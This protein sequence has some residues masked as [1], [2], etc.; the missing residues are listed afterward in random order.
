MLD[1]GSS[2]TGIIGYNN[3]GVGDAYDRY[4]HAVV[5]GLASILCL[6][7]YNLPEAISLCVRNP[8]TT[9]YHHT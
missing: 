1:T 6:A 7:F 9:V 5:H 4:E 3:P 8:H 2:N